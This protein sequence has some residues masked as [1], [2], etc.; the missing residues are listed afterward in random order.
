MNRETNTGKQV[1]TTR[2]KQKSLIEK[3]HTI[4]NITNI[5]VHSYHTWILNFEQ[6]SYLQRFS[7]LY[8]VSV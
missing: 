8:I 2:F 3:T 5:L 7:R 4:R 6:I 1:S